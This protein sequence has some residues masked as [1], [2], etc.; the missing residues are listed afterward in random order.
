MKEKIKETIFTKHTEDDY[1]R[2]RFSDLPK[3]LKDDDIID[4]YR[5]EP[6]IDGQTTYCGY[7]EL[8]IIRE[9]EE[10][11]KEHQERLLEYE[12]IQENLKRMRYNNY[13]KLKTEF[14]G[15]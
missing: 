4:I 9:R 2:F 7:S 6:N 11:D 10:T 8:V 1:Y 3:D 12:K 5:E 14:E 13:L 15:Q